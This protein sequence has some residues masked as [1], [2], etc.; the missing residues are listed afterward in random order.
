MIASAVASL[1]CSLF[2]ASFALADTVTLTELP[3]PDGYP[4]AGVANIAADGTVIGV[5]YPS[6][7]VVRWSPGASPEVLGGGMTFTLDNIMP[8][9]SK[10]GSAIAT[11]GYFAGAGDALVAA[12]ELWS[13]GTD[14]TRIAGTT[15]GN[16]SP[17]GVSYDGQTLVGSAEP[18]VP[19]AEGPWPQLPWMWTATTGQVELG[20]PADTFSGEVW[21]V[22]N[23]GNVA[24]GFIELTP[25]D[26]T[27]YG[28]RW[29][30]G[31]PTWILDA[32]GQRV[33]Q[34]LGCNSDCSVVVGAGV[35]GTAGSK[36]AWRWSEAA[37]VQYLDPP[38]GA[39]TDDVA[40]AF[41]SSEDGAAIVG[42]YVVFDPALGP[43]NH[44]F[45][46][47]AADGM[48]DITQ[49]LADHGIDFGAADWVDLLVD[50]I[51]PDGKTLLVNGMDASYTRRRAVVH[52]VTD[53]WI[54]ADGFDPIQSL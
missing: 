12:P 45:L 16:A 14:W 5:V 22:S 13:G 31:M 35:T 18:A 51:T 37:G 26:E 39:G 28:V 43:T 11:A 4:V 34:A 3:A 20:L 38:P 27:R 19:P 46:W 24:A 44:G 9:I 49:Y 41:E 29:V 7:L 53:D 17:Y 36:R 52:I 1:A 6:G 54:F 47:T 10:S 30:G 2:L 25:D 33:G 15:L 23:D 42:S 40:Y 8:L 32:D 21:A 48:Q 50:A